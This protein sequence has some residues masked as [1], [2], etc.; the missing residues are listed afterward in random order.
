MPYHKLE[1]EQG[2]LLGG[3]LL[4]ALAIEKRPVQTLVDEHVRVED[5]FVPG[6]YSHIYDELYGKYT[7]L[8]LN[9]RGGLMGRTERIMGGD[10][11]NMRLGV[12][13]VDILVGGII[14]HLMSVPILM[15]LPWLKR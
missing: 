12:N 6:G 1:L 15:I 7:K 13:T 10:R 11:E 9:T 2:A 3:I 5:T 8:Y 14:L 4:C